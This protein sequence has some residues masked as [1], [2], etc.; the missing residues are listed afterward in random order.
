MIN[1]H[2]VQKGINNSWRTPLDLAQDVRDLF[3]GSIGLDPCT[4]EVNP[5]RAETYYT[6]DGL[7]LPWQDRTW[8]NPPYDQLPQWLT[9]LTEEST[10]GYRIGLL[11]S[12]ARTETDLIQSLPFTCVQMLRG[13]LRHSEGKPAMLASFIYW[14]NLDP[15]HVEKEM[16]WRGIV[17]RR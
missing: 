8:C 17:L 1:E 11:L 7:L 16:G 2:Y 15:D 6:K 14:F 10:H 13:K 5:L 9:K 3:G 12:V 4:E